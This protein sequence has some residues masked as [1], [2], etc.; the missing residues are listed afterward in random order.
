MVATSRRMARFWIVF[1]LGVVASCDDIADPA[2]AQPTHQL[3]SAAVG[4]TPIIHVT[5]TQ[6]LYDAVNDPSHSPAAIQLAAGTYVLSDVDGAGATRPNGGRL[7]LQ[8]DM[9]LHGVA[10]NRSKVVID[11]SGLPASSLVVSFGRTG[12]VRV[13]RGFNSIQSLTIVGNSAAVAGIETDLDGTA[14]TQIRVESVVSIGSIRGIDVR[15]V[16]SAMAGRRID[17]TLI[18]N[19]LVASQNVQPNQGIRLVNMNGADGG[20]I[21]ATLRD[22]RV[23]GSQFGCLV[24]NLVSSNAVIQVQ[25]AGDRFFDNAIG[26][27]VGGGIVTGTTGRANSNST[28]F[29]AH[30]SAFTDNTH[31]SPLDRGGILLVGGES[32]NLANG[33]SGNTVTVRLWGTKVERNQDQDLT[34]FGARSLTSGVAGTN[35]HA[36]LELHGTSKTIDVS[37]TASLPVDASG[38]NTVTVLR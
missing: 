29:E 17:I 33:T 7:D 24:N 10:G 34:V 9:S 5:T 14:S 22:N 27:F 1:A 38:S 16:G 37:L 4:S 19:D 11:A 3:E 8:K 21:V 32:A 12:P 30:G 36:R 23:H 18:G 35:N 20:V 28:T 25:S 31:A 2:P 13:G 26:C 15:N 6:Q